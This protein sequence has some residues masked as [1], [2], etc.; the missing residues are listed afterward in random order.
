MR[1]ILLAL[2]CLL[3]ALQTRCGPSLERKSERVLHGRPLSG[4][5][6]QD[7]DDY[8]HEA[9]LGEDLAAQ[10]DDLA[11]EESQRRLGLIVDGIG[12]DLDGKVSVEELGHWIKF[13]QNRCHGRCGASVA[14]GII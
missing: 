12:S 9:F 2:S 11:P 7:D 1:R 10:F 13:T 5:E 8:D 3:L 4:M 14:R 6:H